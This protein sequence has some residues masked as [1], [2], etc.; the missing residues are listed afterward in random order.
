VIFAI[1]ITKDKQP[2]SFKFQ[3]RP[4]INQPPAAISRAVASASAARREA[5]RVF[6]KLE[7]QEADAAGVIGQEYVLQVAQVETK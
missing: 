5:E 4:G 7:W 2:R 6:G 1:A 3:V